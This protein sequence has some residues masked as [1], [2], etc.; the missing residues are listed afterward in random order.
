MTTKKTVIMFVIAF[1]LF[2]FISM[3]TTAQKDLQDKL[4][5]LVDTELATYK[6][7]VPDYPGGLAMK[8]ISKQKLFLFQPG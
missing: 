8:V 7:K 6:E 5:E 1:F 3:I 2:T 4:Q